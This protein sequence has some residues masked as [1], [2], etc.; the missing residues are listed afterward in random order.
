MVEHYYYF[1]LHATAN[2]GTNKYSDNIKIRLVNC[3]YTSLSLVEP[4][5][6]PVPY[7]ALDVTSTSE[8]TYIFKQT[9]SDFIECRDITMKQTDGLTLPLTWPGTPSTKLTTTDA[10]LSGN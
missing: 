5:P 7:Y 3:K 9:T 2:G 1:R 6:T 4:Y 10:I 8:L